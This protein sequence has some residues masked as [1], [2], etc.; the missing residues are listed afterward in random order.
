MFEVDSFEDKNQLDKHDFIGSIEI[1][2]H[3]IVCSPTQ[4]IIKPIMNEKFIHFII[5]H[6]K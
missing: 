3:E 1:S 4:S 2:L 5:H 6:L